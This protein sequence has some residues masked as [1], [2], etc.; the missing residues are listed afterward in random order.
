M[1]LDNEVLANVR[2]LVSSGFFRPDDIEE[3]V[4]D[5]YSN[6]LNTR[7]LRAAIKAEVNRWKSEMKNWPKTTDWDRLYEAFSDIAEEWILATHNAG[8]TQSDGY[9]IF[10]ELL[11]KFVNPELYSG[12]CYYTL[13]DVEG[14][15]EFGE[16][17]VSFGPR[18]PKLEKTLGVKIGK[19]IVDALEKQG[20]K[21]KWNG[22]FNQ[23]IKIPD[24]KWQRRKVRAGTFTVFR[25]TDDPPSILIC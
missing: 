7:S 19:T 1:P 21:T 14:A 12:Y 11:E 8:Y 10:L 3:Y 24:F 22:K 6:S 2:F 13:Q 4:Q 5:E 16:L 25:G 20:L 9:D 17:Y 23:R 18:D 15:I